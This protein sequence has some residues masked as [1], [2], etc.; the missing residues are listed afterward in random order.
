MPATVDLKSEAP[1]NGAAVRPLRDAEA[2]NAC[3]PKPQEY[4]PYL[5]GR[6]AW[7]ER[8]GDLVSWAQT[9][10]RLAII[11][12]CIALLETV[13]FIVMIL[14]P[15]KVIVVAVN[16]AGQFLGTGASDQSVAV[17]EGMK[18]SALSEWV[19]NMRLVTPDGGSQRGAI[20]K[21]YA[22]ISSG[23]SAQSM[24]SDFYR[25]EPPQTRAL[26]QTV[27]VEVN[28]VLPTSEKTYEVE[29]VEITRDLQGKMLY[30]QRWKGAFSYVVSASPPSDE[31]LSRLNPIG[32]YITEARWSKVL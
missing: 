29:W 31:R 16:S 28:S 2:T 7:D 15:P 12:V 8:Y 32:L 1:G 19:S 21:V 27:H 26:N 4:N 17:T 20:E 9:A 5:A 22:M 23:S 11:S 3:Q 13:A 14:R 25:G 30:Q 10:N 24:I 18:R 6:R